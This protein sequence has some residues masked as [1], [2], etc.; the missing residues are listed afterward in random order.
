MLCFSLRAVV[1]NIWRARRVQPRLLFLDE[2]SDRC[3]QEAAFENSVHLQ[4][5]NR[6]VLLFVFVTVIV[7]ALNMESSTHYTSCRDKERT[8]STWK[9]CTLQVK[10]LWHCTYNLLIRNSHNSG[11]FARH[12]ACARLLRIKLLTQITAYDLLNHSF[13]VKQFKLF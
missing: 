8:L 13:P 6:Q 11:F 5:W 4:P 7:S 3:R 2:I 10:T 9:V 1:A 12:L